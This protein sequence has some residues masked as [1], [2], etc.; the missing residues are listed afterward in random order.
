MWQ[1]LGELCVKI[2][3]EGVCAEIVRERIGVD[4]VECD[5]VVWDIVLCDTLCVYVCILPDN[6]D[7]GKVSCD[8]LR[9]GGGKTMSGRK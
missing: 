1:L 8:N 6:V 4:K 7:F 2:G 9:G 3:P 5:N